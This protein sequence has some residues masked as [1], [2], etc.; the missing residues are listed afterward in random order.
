MKSAW[1][2]ANNCPTHYHQD[3]LNVGRCV[4]L[5]MYITL[6]AAKILLLLCLFFY[7]IKNSVE[8]VWQKAHE[9]PK[10]G[11]NL[12]GFWIKKGETFS[13]RLRS[14]IT[15]TQVITPGLH[16]FRAHIQP[17]YC[18]EFKKN[19]KIYSPGKICKSFTNTQKKITSCSWYNKDHLI[20]LSFM[21]S[22]KLKAD[23]VQVSK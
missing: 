13:L 22:C 19:K 20:I 1:S 8:A 5:N 23:A 7:C 6:D 14:N 21:A 17:S 10:R 4:C 16:T 3:A 2:D 12:H 18:C 15:Q 11:V 9:T